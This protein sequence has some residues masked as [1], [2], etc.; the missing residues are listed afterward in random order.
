M[1][2][3]RPSSSTLLSIAPNHASEPTGHNLRFLQGR[4]GET[5]R[6]PSPMAVYT[7]CTSASSTL[8]EEKEDC[9]DHG[10]DGT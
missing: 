3:P 6:A 7:R 5:S 1:A 4:T 9:H 2:A 10:P 8:E